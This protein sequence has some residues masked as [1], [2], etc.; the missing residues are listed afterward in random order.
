MPVCTE[1][2]HGVAVI[3]LASKNSPL[4]ER[5]EHIRDAIDVLLR[6]IQKTRQHTRLHET[7][8]L[9]EGIL[10]LRTACRIDVAFAQQ[11]RTE[12]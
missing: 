11:I 8:F 1:D 3:P 7:Q 5:L 10:Y 12:Q 2:P 4:V 9:A 6:M